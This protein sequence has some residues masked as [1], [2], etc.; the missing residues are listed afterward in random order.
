M[1]QALAIVANWG[2]HGEAVASAA[3]S[4]SRT[5]RFAYRF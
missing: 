3:K 2:A 5:R 1:F 4:G